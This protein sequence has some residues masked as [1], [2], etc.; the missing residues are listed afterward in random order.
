MVRAKKVDNDLFFYPN[1]FKTFSCMFTVLNYCTVVVPVPLVTLLSRQDF[2][3]LAANLLSWLRFPLAS[4]LV[5]YLCF[6][7]CDVG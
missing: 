5:W 1:V 6:S 2:I 7:S 4:V 3:D